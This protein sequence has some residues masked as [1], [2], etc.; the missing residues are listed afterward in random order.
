MT[1]RTKSAG[2]QAYKLKGGTVK[3]G[4][5]ILQHA[6]KKAEP[7]PLGER[8]PIRVVDLYAALDAEV[9]T[10]DQMAGATRRENDE[11]SSVEWTGAGKRIA[12][13][14]RKLSVG[15]WPPPGDFHVQEPKDNTAETPNK[16]EKAPK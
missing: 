8:P 9:A 14:L 16:P 4:K 2:K 11:K 3:E 13:L 15:E 10:A 7:L 12:F 1:P 5:K 6:A